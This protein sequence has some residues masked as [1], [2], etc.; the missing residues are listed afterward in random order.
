MNTSN[1]SAYDNT[2]GLTTSVPAFYYAKGATRDDFR[3][4]FGSYGTDNSTGQVSKVLL[5]SSAKTGSIVDSETI[6][7]GNNCTQ[8]FGLMSDVATARNHAVAEETQIA[9]A[10]F[11]D[12]WGNLYRYVPSLGSN[13]STG[14]TGS[15]PSPTHQQER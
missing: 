1:T 15:Y 10:Y 3:I 4:V 13:L 2:L 5:N 12:T 8:I 6:N 11:G 14:Q 9:A 7:P